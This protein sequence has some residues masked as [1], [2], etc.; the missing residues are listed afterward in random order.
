M[1]RV[2]GGDE[3]TS[4]WGTIHRV[5]SQ[6]G[7]CSNIPFST[8]DKSNRL[9]LGLSCSITAVRLWGEEM[10]NVTGTPTVTAGVATRLYHEPCS[11]SMRE[12]KTLLSEEGAF[13]HVTKVRFDRLDKRPNK[14]LFGIISID[15]Q[16]GARLHLAP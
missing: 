15:V 3:R 6:D 1:L 9:V 4:Q 8:A 12:P 2:A 14:R 10:R 11:I 16:Y 13:F 7:L 5:Q